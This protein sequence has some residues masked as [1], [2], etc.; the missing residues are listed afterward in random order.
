MPHTK[1]S[2]TPRT[3]RPRV[4]DG[5]YKIV[6]LR[7]PIEDVEQLHQLAAE[8]VRSINAV[9]HRL[10]RKG[11]QAEGHE[12]ASAAPIETAYS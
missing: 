7:W 10:C 9:V 1:P 6:M 3:G 5:E 12:L 2:R 8:E 11:L 4:R